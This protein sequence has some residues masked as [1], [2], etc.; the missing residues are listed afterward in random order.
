MSGITDRLTE[1]DHRELA[2]LL[3]QI[4]D[5]AAAKRER[6]RREGQARESAGDGHGGTA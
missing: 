6:E 1:D 3:R 2:R 4:K 5:R